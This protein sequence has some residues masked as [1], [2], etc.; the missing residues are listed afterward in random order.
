MKKIVVPIL[1]VLMLFTLAT[2]T[3]A[4]SSI[5]LD[6][7]VDGKM[8]SPVPNMTNLSNDN[9][10]AIGGKYQL[11]NK[12]SISGEYTSGKMFRILAFY[13]FGVNYVRI[14]DEI[15]TYNI[16]GGYNVI[17][18]KDL[19]LDLSAGYYNDNEK[20]R[21]REM[22]ICDLE[23]ESIFLGADAL[24]NITKNITVSA[25][26]EYGIS[27]E[28]TAKVDNIKET[29]DLDSLFNYKVGFNYYLTKQLG[30]SL[31]YRS[32]SYEVDDGK[33]TSSGVTTG[34]TYK[35]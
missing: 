19:R 12:W 35:F 8:D 30:I 28:V 1:I 16:K 34:V 22:D 7:M 32:S 29:D 27:G 33:T 21:A 26:F 11:S 10:S 24:F 9:Y 13:D 20:Y 17:D 2:S 15:T 5:Y 25:G 3:L 31:G 23:F 18:N 14:E 6:Y 4:N